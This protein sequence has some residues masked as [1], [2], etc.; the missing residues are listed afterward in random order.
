MGAGTRW[1]FSAAADLR[2]AA[3]SGAR[4]GLMSDIV[5]ICDGSWIAG[6]G[7]QTKHVNKIT[8]GPAGRALSMTVADF[9]AWCRALLEVAQRTADKKWS[10]LHSEEAGQF[11]VVVLLFAFGSG[12]FDVQA[13]HPP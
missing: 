13:S 8:M 11:G 9:A 6:D 4:A 12:S 2:A 3:H 10:R 1:A 5:V 7:T